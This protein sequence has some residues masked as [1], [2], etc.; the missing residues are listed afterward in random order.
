[1]KRKLF[2][3]QYLMSLYDFTNSSYIVDLLMYLNVPSSFLLE[4]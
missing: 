2:P 4:P 3:P 1:M